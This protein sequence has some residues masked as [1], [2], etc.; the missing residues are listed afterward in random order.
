MEAVTRNTGID[1]QNAARRTSKAKGAGASGGPYVQMTLA[2]RNGPPRVLHLIDG[3]GWGGAEHL[4]ALTLPALRDAGFVPR[5][6]TLKVRN[7]NPMAAVLARRG[8]PVDLVPVDRL[9]NL[10]QAHAL[11][12]YIRRQRCDII[13]TTLEAASL[14]GTLSAYALGL[15]VFCSFHTAEIPIGKAR[16]RSAVLH[17]LLR[18]YGGSM[19]CVSEHVRR[20]YI[21]AFGFRPDQLVVLHNGIELAPFEALPPTTRAELRRALA[22]PAAAPVIVTV[23]VLRPP[24]GIA[25]MIEAMPA[26]LA[27]QPEARYLIVGDGE[28]RGALA[29]LAE[30][31][32]LAHRVV[33]T[34][35]RTDIPAILSSVD[36]FALPSLNDALPTVLAEAMAAGLPI[37]ASAIGG[38]PEMVEPG[39]NGILVQPGSAGEF[40]AAWNRLLAAP[41]LAAAMGAQGRRIAR[42]LF[43]LESHVTRLSALYAAALEKRRRPCASPS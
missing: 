33:F 15:P 38:I 4:L 20:H 11:H 35:T 36:G 40:A 3:L 34:G 14:Y 21:E 9:R 28:A 2:A 43:A 10:R 41:E 12:A 22:I 31:L 39:V 42:E 5:V 1:G 16:R 27:H 6:A 30:R 18:H 32:G 8:I 29:A 7:G 13:H 26:I 37:V 17:W 19:L 23:A 25:T 24:K